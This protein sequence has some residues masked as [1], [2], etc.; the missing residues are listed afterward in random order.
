MTHLHR[1]MQVLPH[2]D[3]CGSRFVFRQVG[4]EKDCICLSSKQHLVIMI[5]L[6]SLAII[7]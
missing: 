7:C 3:R 6:H 5:M 2:K 1:Y 4:P